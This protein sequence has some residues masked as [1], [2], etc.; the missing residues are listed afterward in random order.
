[1][2]DVSGKLLKGIK[3][4]YV[5]SLACVRLKGV[6]RECFRIDRCVRQNLI[7]SPWLFNMYMDAVMKEVKIRMG[8]MGVRFLEE[9]REWRL[10]CLLYAYDLVLYSES[11]EGV[12][13]MVRRFVEVLGGEEGGE[14]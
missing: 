3:S 11:E 8:K 14:V 4:A 1:M 9:G 12:K 7:M 6:E 5:N 10:L 2:Y 13:V